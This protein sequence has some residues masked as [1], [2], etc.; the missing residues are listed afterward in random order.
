MGHFRAGRNQLYVSRGLNCTIIPLRI[1]C[2]PEVTII[3]LTGSDGV[4]P[5][6]A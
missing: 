6:A 5:E 1:H 3:N 4:S 2:P